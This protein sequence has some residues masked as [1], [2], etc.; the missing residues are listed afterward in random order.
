[1]TNKEAI[2][3]LRDIY[4]EIDDVFIFTGDKKIEALDLAI[5]ALEERTQGEWELHGMIYYCSVC[6]H[7][8]G[9]S[10]DNFCGNCGAEMRSEPC[11]HDCDQCEHG[12]PIDGQFYDDGTPIKEC[13]IRPKEQSEQEAKQYS[14]GYQD[15]FLD[16]K[17]MFG[18]DT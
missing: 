6:G 8:C 4:K 18:G 1:M 17:K 14:L 11:S 16:A 10:G 12:V 3:E 2:E 9:E 7:E 15:G 13:S 5:K